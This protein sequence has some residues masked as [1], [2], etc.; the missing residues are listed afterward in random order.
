MTRI[1][2]MQELKSFT[3]IVTKDFVLPVPSQDDSSASPGEY[4]APG[5][6]LANLPDPDQASEYVPYV[7]HQMVVGRYQH[8]A[9]QY[10]VFTAN[11]RSVFV[12]YDPDAERGGI[13]LLNLM[14]RFQ[15][16]LIEAGGL[17]RQFKLNV[18]EG[19]ESLVYPNSDQTRPFYGGEMSTVWW[20]PAPERRI[21]DR[22]VYPHYPLINPQRS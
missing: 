16:A 18:L 17:A 5:V 20:V 4:R 22:P 6:Y 1:E 2:L 3:E 15:T 7:L 9:E 10:P 12:V 14:D 21:P 19:I 13:M 11:V 8:E